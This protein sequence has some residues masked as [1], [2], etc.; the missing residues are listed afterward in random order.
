MAKTMKDIG[1]SPPHVSEFIRKTYHMVMTPAEIFWIP[2]PENKKKTIHQTDEFIAAV[3]ELNGLKEIF[4]VPS[5]PGA[6]QITCSAQAPD[7]R[8]KINQFG[9]VIFIDGVHIDS[10]LC[11][12]LF[13]VTLLDRNR[14]IQCGRPFFLG[15]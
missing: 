9:D 15:S 2:V 8:E 6:L 5:D 3:E 10:K 7:E 13:S 4:R 1:T 11:W 14:Q 12:D